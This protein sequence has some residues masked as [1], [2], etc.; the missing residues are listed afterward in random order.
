LGDFDSVSPQTLEHFRAKGV[1]SVTYDAYKD[2]SDLELALS[3]LR[4]R[5]FETVI[6]TNV[7][8]GRIDHE[9]AALGNLAAFA[10][11]GTR[12]VL[13]EENESCVFLSAFEGCAESALELEF[14]SAPAPSVISLIPWGGEAVVSIQGVEWE[15]DHA[16]LVPASS[17]GVSNV[18][19]SS[20]VAITVHKGTAI[21]VLQLGQ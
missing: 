8:G 20:R 11:R 12:V 17:R 6:A 10:E 3:V 1:E 21:V 9:L 7:L 4:Q 18:V 2:S 14:S 15:L 13:A 16:T 5:G 19:A